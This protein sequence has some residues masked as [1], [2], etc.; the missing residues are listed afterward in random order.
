MILSLIG[1]SL[2]LLGS[3]FVL[4]RSFQV[5]QRSFYQVISLLIFAG[6]LAGGLAVAIWTKYSR[7]V[8]Q[9]ATITL[10]DSQKQSCSQCSKDRTLQ[11]CQSLINV[12]E[13]NLVETTVRK[14]SLWIGWMWALFYFF[15]NTS[16][17]IFGIKYLD[18]SVMIQDIL[19]N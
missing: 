7:Y 4:V 15:F 9:L 19:L 8:S 5:R 16:N 17:L 12:N 3:T 10:N 6:T 2:T 18:L 13:I 11:V 14:L 1:G